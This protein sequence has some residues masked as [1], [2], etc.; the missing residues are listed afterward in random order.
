MGKIVIAKAK[1][2]DI[3]AVSKDFTNMTR[4]EISHFILEMEK[5]KLEL[6]DRWINF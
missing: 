3:V 4:G 5:L 6:L 1:N 2:Q